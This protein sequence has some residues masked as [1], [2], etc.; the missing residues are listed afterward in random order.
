MSKI[1]NQQDK[2]PR[3]IAISSGKGGVG[4][5]TL[6][7][8]LGIALAKAGNKVCLFDADT[9]LANINILLGISPLHTLEHY[10]KH[11]I[12]LKDIIIKGPGDI[13]IISGASGVSEF[14]ELSPAHQA[15]LIDA[16]RILEKNH[17]YLLIDTAAGIDTTNINLLLAAPYL[18]LC[19]SQEPTSLTD[20]FS[21]LRVLLKHR[22]AHPV[23]VIVNMAASHQSAQATFRRFKSA[24]S[25]YLHLKIYFAGHVLA[26]KNLPKSILNQR[27]VILEKPQS[28]ASQC[29]TAISTRLDNAF[30]KYSLQSTSLSE[31]LAEVLSYNGPAEAVDNTEFVPSREE[32]STIETTVAISAA[33]SGT[34]FS[35]NSA[36]LRASHF[37]RLLGKNRTNKLY[38]S[39][40]K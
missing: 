23:L 14:I 1:I 33:S 17:Q 12:A 16:L 6:T 32:T 10:L 39:S 36:L 7:V 31:H 37:A 34:E 19:I 8:N 2:I 27:P 24:V 18:L 15:K 4:K 28:P 5:T 9:N 26:D 21:L 35:R 25:Q 22:F 29:I 11:N 38:K 30:S 40:F 20:A 3:I 13:N